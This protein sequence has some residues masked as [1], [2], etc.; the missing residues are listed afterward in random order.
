MKDKVRGAIVGVAIGDALGMPVE[1]L[2]PKT[3]KKYF[4]RIET[5][6]TPNPKTKCFHKL[7]RGQWT[8][9][10][11]LTLAI[12][13]SIADKKSIDYEDIADKHVDMF[14]NG[15]RGWGG[16]TKNGIRKILNGGNWWNSGDLNAA[17]NGP[18]MK[19]APIGVL[20]GLKIIN[21]IEMITACTNI[22]KMTHGDP[23]AIVG[24]ILQCMLIRAALI[25]GTASLKGEMIS[26]Q[27]NAEYLEDNFSDECLSRKFHNIIYIPRMSNKKIRD[28]FGVGPFINESLPFAYAMVYKYI[29][30]PGK[31]LEYIVNQGGDADTTGAIAGSLLGAAHG[32][33]KFPLKWRRGL[34]GRTRLIK[35]ADNLLKLGDS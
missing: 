21:K 16:A 8:D 18:P 15:K 17:G 12:G 35:L 4:K 31:C 6:R 26:L 25:G 13:E 19:I 29:N 34:E 2:K 5:Y 24:A 32:Y 28:F 33:S 14:L 30:N 9:D 20:Y 10:T 1:S 7:K 3:I 22:S 23:R 27:D 11:Q